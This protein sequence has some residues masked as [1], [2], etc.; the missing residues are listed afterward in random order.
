MSK[1]AKIIFFCWFGA[2]IAAAQDTS[3]IVG[4]VTDPSGAAI[5]GAQVRVSNVQKGFVRDLTT[6]SAGAYT[7]AKVPIGNYT[8]TVQ[9][10]GFER[11]SN[12]GIE[13]TVGQTLRVDV[14]MPIGSGTQEVTVAGTVAGVETETGTISDVI[15]RVPSHAV[16]S[17]W[18]QLYQPGDIDSGGCAGKLQSVQRRG[19]GVFRDLVQWGARA[20]Q[21]LGDRWHQ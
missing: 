4:V 17:E 3:T 12:A 1:A 10:Q 18:A 6:D 16:E 13:L 15:T 9:A 2:L 8:V 11:V 14:Q 21:Q 7:A 20:I 19:A 5:P